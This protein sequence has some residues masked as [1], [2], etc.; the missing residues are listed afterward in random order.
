M[1]E[2]IDLPAFNGKMNA[3][4]ALDWIEALTTFFECEDIPKKG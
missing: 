1:E 3:D 4:I 2:K